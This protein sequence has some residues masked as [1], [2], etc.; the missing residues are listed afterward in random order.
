MEQTRREKKSRKEMRR[1]EKKGDEEKNEEK[2]VA[3][4]RKQEEKVQIK[5]VGGRVKKEEEKWWEIEGKEGL[6]EI[7][8]GY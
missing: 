7:K 2:R 1:E 8:A 4:K 5:C 6:N 3:E